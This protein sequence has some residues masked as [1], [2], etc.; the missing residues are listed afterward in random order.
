MK[1][2][3]EHTLCGIFC[4]SFCGK[5][6]WIIFVSISFLD[7]FYRTQKYSQKESHKMFHKNDSQNE[8]HKN[9]FL[10]MYSE[11]NLQ[12]CGFSVGLIFVK[13]VIIFT[14]FFRKCFAKIFFNLDSQNDQGS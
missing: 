7:Y 4:G 5:F 14:Y 10:Q 11:N 8:I 6:L 13:L 1:H 12:K 3:V 2:F 9:F